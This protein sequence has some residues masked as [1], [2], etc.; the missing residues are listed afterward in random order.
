M[1]VDV[2]CGGP[3]REAEVSRRSGAAILKGLLDAGHDVVLHDR[4][5]TLDPAVL[6]PD[7]VVFNIIHGTYGE[8]GTLQAELER[9]GRAFVGSD[10]AASRLCMDKQAT[11][12]RLAAAGI[13]VPWGAAIDLGTPFRPTD[14]RLPHLG[15]L[16]L[17]PR[18]DG[19][20]VGLRLISGPSFLLP[21]CEELLAEVG[22]RRYLIEERLPGPEYTCAV[23]DEDGGP[24]ALPPIAIRPA[25]GVFDYHAKYHS[26]DTVEE[27]VAD[28]VLAARLAAAAVAAHRACGCRDLSRTDL[29]R[30]AD[31]DYAV[32]EINTL[33][34][35]TGASLTPKAAAAAGIGFSALV[36]RLVRRAAA[37]SR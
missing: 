37:R 4:P 1:R 21:T 34:G 12:E 6:R 15:G 23:I 27:P 29:M 30:T 28:P 7:S 16:V 9:L 11:K 17:K 31:D 13:R 36:D 10:A 14:L 24:R 33:P 20:S 19:S 5:G 8:D 22:P 32:L 35:F 25:G 18:D 2:L 26:A 3:G